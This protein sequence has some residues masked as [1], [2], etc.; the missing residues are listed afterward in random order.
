MAPSAVSP[1]PSP[2][3]TPASTNLDNLPRILVPEK[4]SPEG[5]ALLRATGFHV[6]TPPPASLSP[7]DLL[8]QIPSYH[9]L[10]VRSETKVTSAV[11]AAASKLR[12]VARAGVGVDNIDVPAATQHGVIVVNS[13][14]GNIVAAAEHTIALL[15]AVARNVGRADAGMKRGAWERGRLVGVEV[16]RKTLGIVGFGKVGV[17]VARMAKG[18]GMVV[19]V[20]DP[21]ASKEVAEQAGVELRGELGGLLPDVDFLTVHTPLLASTANLLGEKELQSMKKT[22]RVLNVARGGVY[23]EEALLKALDEGWIAGAGLDVFTSEPP[24]E[25]SV[26]AKLAA[27]PKVVSTPHLGASTVEAQENVSMDVCTQVVEI[28]KGGLPTAAVNAPLI[29]PEEYRRLQPFVK[30]IERMGSLYTQHFAERGGMVGGRRF[31]LVYHGELAGMSNTRPLFAALV[32]GLVSSISDLGGRDV[33]IV[34]ATLIARE[35][36]IAIDEKHVR[37]GGA[38]PTY[39]SAV[40]LRSLSS[41]AGAGSGS[42][43]VIEGYVSGNTVFI[44]K[45]DRFAANFQP[46]GTLLV[47]HNYDEPG[48]IGNV[49][50]VLGKHGVNINFMQVAALEDGAGPSAA[51]PV[52]DGPVETAGRAAREALMILGVAGDVTEGLLGELGKSEGILHVIL[53]LGGSSTK[54]V[55]M[56]AQHTPRPIPFAVMDDLSRMSDVDEVA[57]ADERGFGPSSRNI[58]SPAPKSRSLSDGGGTPRLRLSPSPHIVEAALRQSKDDIAI[59][60]KDHEH[61]PPLP[62]TPVRA[63]FPARGLSLQMPPRE[64]ASPACPSAYARPAPHSPKPE[65]PYASPTNILPRRSRGMDFS[66]AAT[67]LHHSTLADPASPDSSPTI[68]S[69]AMNIPGR[70]AAEY[71][72]TDQTSTSLWS[73]MGNQE[74]M[75]ISSSVGSTA[76]HAI[77]DLSSTSDDDDYMD[78]DME[79][80]YVTTPQVQKVGMSSAASAM[81]APWMPGS[82]AASNLLSFQQRQRQRKH[83]KKKPRGPIGLGFHSPA[84]PAAM[85]KSPPNN[86]VGPND[87]SP[88]ARRESISWAANQLHIS[89]NESDDSHRQPDGVDSPS[90]PSI[91]RRAVTRRG[92]LL[93]KT[94][95]FARIRAALAEESAPV[96]SE[97]RREAEVVRQVRESDMDLEPRYPPSQSAP[98][99]AL[100]SPNLATHDS[101]E[102]ITDDI[103]MMDPTASALGVTGTFK[104]QAMKNS[105]GK[106]FWDTFSETSSTGGTQR[107]TPPP[108]SLGLARGSSS[109]FSLEDVSMGSPSASS[110]GGASQSNPFVVPGGGGGAQTTTSSSGHGTPLPPPSHGANNNHNN[111]ANN[112][113]SSQGPTVPGGPMGMPTPPTAAEITRRINSKRRRDDDL[114]PV[115]IKRRAVSPGMS[116]HNSPVMQ[117]PLQRDMA[118]WGSAGPGVGGDSSAGGGG[119]GGGGAGRNGS[120][121]GSEN[122]SSHGGGGGGGHG[123]SNRGGGKVRVGFQGMVETN[124]GITR[125]SIE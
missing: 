11:L 67:S 60:D 77:S 102:E 31:E 40:T 59:R 85:S 22:A 23:N 98:S 50:M 57:V 1:P 99:T 29:L 109:G 58:R 65:H 14:S 18:L 94:K 90:R 53:A 110:N 56:R 84:G 52:V 9:A 108:P 55:C 2:T 96:E 89:G 106:V 97:F 5:L 27:H 28:L 86:M 6:D 104:Q 91:V 19:V 36:G 30:L 43:Q 116:V 10:I 72:A 68:G 17:Q 79:E 119:G 117:S 45:L 111:P 107:V 46:E 88:H 82:P 34:N 24:V 105:K 25:G 48:K 75:H 62:S 87:M 74:R 70:R 66:R 118:P 71:G 93:P 73:M 3:T 15:L 114:D 103:M 120:G 49:G 8:R 123:G 38:V 101:L 20:F 121:A 12:V 7:A 4:L 47:L 78:E 115:S 26:A 125:L 33:N 92:N 113:S 21:Y 39:A 63:G 80:A 61:M 122:G 81:G 44:S 69:R 32:K 124:D 95:G 64:P 112:H 37:D 76:G 100:S 13:P 41:E 35:R 51:A 16:G 83:P 42:E 54:R